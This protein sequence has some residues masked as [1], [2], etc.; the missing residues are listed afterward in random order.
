MR[1]SP[2]SLLALELLRKACGG[3]DQRV[4]R[5][6]HGGL[7]G[8]LRDA[9]GYRVYLG[10]LVDAG[11]AAPL[12]PRC[13]QVECTTAFDGHGCAQGFGS[14]RTEHLEPEERQAMQF[15]RGTRLSLRRYGPTRSF[16]CILEADEHNRLDHDLLRSLCQKGAYY[17]LAGSAYVEVE[18]HLELWGSG[19]PLAWARSSLL[20][21]RHRLESDAWSYLPL[22]RAKSGEG[23]GNPAEAPPGTHGVQSAT[24]VPDWG[25]DV[26][27]WLAA[28]VDALRYLGLLYGRGAYWYV[29]VERNCDGDGVEAVQW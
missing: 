15:L 8:V 18:S 2:G 11:L 14:R 6:G 1:I 21:G 28:V 19:N 7:P 12:G 5:L 16:R 22:L 27:H 25:K 23:T 13:Y 24:L 20:Q 3:D 4:V 9:R 17:W 10:E 29:D 26:G